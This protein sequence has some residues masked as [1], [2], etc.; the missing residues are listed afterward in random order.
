VKRIEPSSQGPQNLGTMAIFIDKTLETCDEKDLC[1]GRK[2]CVVKAQKS[3][4]AIRDG[5]LK[6]NFP[7]EKKR[8]LAMKKG[9]NERITIWQTPGLPGGIYVIKG[10]GKK[11]KRAKKRGLFK[12]ERRKPIRKG[13]KARRRS[14][15]C[16]GI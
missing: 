7:S 4:G 3:I 13:G 14:R 6:K 1:Q 5:K 15:G 8:L 10:A 16:E 12:E 2:I 9:K 11:G